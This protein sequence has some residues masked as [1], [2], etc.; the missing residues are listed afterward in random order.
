MKHYL[1]PIRS[2]ASILPSGDRR[3]ILIV[4]FVQISLS[5]FDLLGVALIGV[6]G[7]LSF[8]G[9]RGLENGNRTKQ[10]LELIG[11]ESFSFYNQIAFLSAV[12]VFVL[13][14]KTALSMYFSQ[15]YLLFLAK[16]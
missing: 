12:A 9:I 8:S 3:K 4:C 1:E 14:S 5:F 7:A 15:K 13:I 10:A 2:A 11:L 16:R 6:I